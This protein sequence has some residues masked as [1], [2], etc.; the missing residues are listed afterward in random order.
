MIHW[1]EYWWREE[2]HAAVEYKA[3]QE[4]KLFKSKVDYNEK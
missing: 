4:Q 1:Y 3:S 2:L